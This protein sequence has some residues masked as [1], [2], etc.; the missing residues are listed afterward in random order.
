[1]NTVTVNTLWRDGTDNITIPVGDVSRALKGKLASCN[2]MSMLE[3]ESRFCH[4]WRNGQGKNRIILR[5]I[6]FQA[7]LV[8]GGII[9]FHS[10]MYVSIYFYCS[11]LN[12]DKFQCGNYTLQY[13]DNMAFVCVCVCVCVL[14]LLPGNMSNYY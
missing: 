1:M 13:V 5:G 6:V 4:F 8:S 14:N 2:I 10:F 11:A 9:K 3:R 12:W 7:Q